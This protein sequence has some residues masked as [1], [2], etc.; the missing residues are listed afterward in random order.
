MG[1]PPF[2]VASGSNKGV[3]GWRK[4]QR[5]NQAG[6]AT[7]SN[8]IEV[9]ASIEIDKDSPLRQRQ[10]QAPSKL[11]QNDGCG[12]TKS[13][14]ASGSTFHDESWPFGAS[15]NLVSSNGIK[16]SYNLEDLLHF[17]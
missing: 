8:N 14:S 1:P 9:H 11:T 4:P 7:K 2:L 5:Q 16:I 6:Q 10:R 17:V 3:C 15:R 13:T 12:G